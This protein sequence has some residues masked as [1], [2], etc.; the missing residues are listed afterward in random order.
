MIRQLATVASAAFVCAALLA[1]P[2]GAQAPAKPGPDAAKG[3]TIANTVCAA[4]HAADG[5]SPVA[6]NPKLAGQG[7]EYL[8]KQL[9][10]F[11]PQAGKKPQR[12][13]AV[14]AGMVGNLSDDDMKNVA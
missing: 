12:D 7:Y 3:Q 5:N 6:A 4:C 1:G 10:N 11:K 8:H 9:V 13:N 14:M 2:A